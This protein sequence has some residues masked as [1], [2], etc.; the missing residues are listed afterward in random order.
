MRI[1]TVSGRGRMA[2]STCA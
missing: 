2:C 1:G